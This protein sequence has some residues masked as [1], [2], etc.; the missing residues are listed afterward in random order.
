VP[1]Q[2]LVRKAPG[3]TTQKL[4]TTLSRETGKVI[5]LVEDVNPELIRVRISSDAISSN[6]EVAALATEGRASQLASL[7]TVDSIEPVVNYRL[8]QVN[9]DAARTGAANAS[10]MKAIEFEPASALHPNLP[11]TPIIVAVID[12]GVLLDHEIFKGLLLPGVDITSG[13][14]SAK[15]K[16]L[17]NGVLEFHGTGTAGLIALLIRGGKVDGTPLANIKILPIRATNVDASGQAISS[18]DAIKAMD[19][20]IRR[21]AKIINVSW[22]DVADSKELKLKFAEA[23]SRNILIFAAAGNGRR[24]SPLEQFRGYDIDQSPLYP[25]GWHIPNIVGV[26]ASGVDTPLASFS[27]WGRSS[28]GIAAPGEGIT[29]PTPLVSADGITI[30]SGYQAQSGT[31]LSTPIAAAV[32]ALYMAARPDVE[33]HTLATL[34]KDSATKVSNLQN[35]VTSGG[36]LS[37]KGLLAMQVPVVQTAHPFALSLPHGAAMQI[38]VDM[39][40]AATSRTLESGAPIL[41][42]LDANGKGILTKNLEQFLVRLPPGKSPRVVLKNLPESFGVIE[43]VKQVDTNL[44][45]I[46]VDAPKG[47]VAT[48]KTLKQFPDVVHVE[49]ATAYRLQNSMNN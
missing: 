22:A 13:E 34:L 7:Q 27:N 47:G 31:S 45:S 44:Y 40:R 10:L 43:G 21:G 14:E 35:M 15:A 23:D 49:R 39:A 32:A 41:R 2:F 20:A 6:P 5:Y 19:F 1:N 16:A 48:E 17:S 11:A 36:R 9:T 12:T 4:L 37:M 33:P 18:S 8:A 24:S 38:S 30:N 3:F 26:A 28:I 25:A 29:A 46:D 42:G